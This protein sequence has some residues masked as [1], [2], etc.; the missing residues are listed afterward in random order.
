MF[1]QYVGNY[2]DMG[3]T[4]LADN[5]QVQVGTCNPDTVANRLTCS[6]Y[7]WEQSNADDFEMKFFSWNS[8]ASSEFLAPTEEETKKTWKDF[9]TSSSFP[10]EDTIV[11]DGEIKSSEGNFTRSNKVETGPDLVRAESGT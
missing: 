10:T 9:M 1:V 6:A 4:V 2:V 11:F 7:T 8:P 3:T 5:G